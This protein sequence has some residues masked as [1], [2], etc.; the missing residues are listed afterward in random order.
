MT[1][2]LEHAADGGHIHYAKRKVIEEIAVDGI[3]KDVT[4]AFKERQY[5]GRSTEAIVKKISSLFP[6]YSITI[7]CDF[8]K[9]E[10]VKI[11]RQ[12]GD[13]YRYLVFVTYTLIS[14]KDK[15]TI[16]STMIGDAAASGDRGLQSA[17]T[18]CYKN[19]LSQTFCIAEGQDDD[20]VEQKAAAKRQE[21]KDEE[22]KERAIKVRDDLKNRLGSIEFPNEK[23]EMYEKEFF[24][25]VNNPK[26]PDNIKKECL[27]FLES[28]GV[29]NSIV[30]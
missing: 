9:Y 28:V 23:Q 8:Q 24:N 19:F 18:I 2:N 15:S 5:K 29:R 11:P 22:I 16:S 6:K 26:F 25:K 7:S 13:E 27:A 20:H 3:P 1:E 14:D 4:V 17:L 12:H 30:I 10:L 21:N